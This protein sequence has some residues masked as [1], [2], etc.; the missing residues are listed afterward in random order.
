MGELG[1]SKIETESFTDLK[2]QKTFTDRTDTLH[3]DVTDTTTYNN[4]TDTTT[5]D[6]VT[7]EL[8]YGHTIKTEFNSK[9]KTTYDVDDVQTFD[10]TDTERITLERHANIG[11]TTT[12]KLLTEYVDYAEYFNY[13]DV[14]AKD[15][16][17]A[18][19]LGVY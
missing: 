16:M 9:H 14:V 13:V 10:T 4:V 17:N 3:H 1:D 11:V 12:T 18:F 15:L 7:D 19:T 5:Y 8:D 2:D 6:D